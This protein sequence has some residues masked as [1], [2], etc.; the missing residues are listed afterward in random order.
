MILRAETTRFP[1]WVMSFLM[2]MA[3]AAHADTAVATP[4][5][6]IPTP[7]VNGQN[8]LD[9]YMATADDSYAWKLLEQ[10][11]AP[12]GTSYS[13]HMTSQ[14]W[15]RPDEV[16]RTEWEHSLTIVKPANVQAD[17]ALLFIGGG[18][19]GGD[20]RSIDPKLAQVALATG[21]VVAELGMVPNQPLIFHGDGQPRYEDDL[22]AYAWAHFLETGDKRWLPRLP[23]VKSAVRAMD[24]IQALMASE[25]GGPLEVKRFVVAGGSKR[26][27]TTW[28][29]AAADRRVAGIMPIVID[30]LNMD[31]SMRHH[32]SAYGFW[33]PAIGDYVHHG[34]MDQ[35][36]SPRYETLLGL[37]DPFAYRDR[38]TMPK[39]VI[40]ATGDQ[41]FVP[42]SSQFYFDELP[43]EKH[44]CYVPNAE[45]SLDK[46]DAL[47]TLIAFHYSIVHDVPRRNSGG[48]TA[49]PTRFA[50]NA[51][52]RLRA[53][54]H[55]GRPRTTLR[56]IF[57][58]I[59]LGVAI[60][61]WNLRRAIG[62]TNSSPGSTI[63]RKVGKPISSNWSS[64]LA[65]PARCV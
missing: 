14:K 18:R 34:I 27:W 30:M 53:A 5:R 8:V 63:H 54:S 21:S 57:A 25:E 1:Y 51:P 17:T 13:V 28:M 9:R 35:R 62:R 59:R 6:A 43:Q 65:R 23:M 36:Y 58:S 49:M 19:N 22:I 32:F 41:F 3:P 15:L 12:Q 20:E 4:R 2:L 39:C 52:S 48:R 44:L 31:V 29:T 60:E 26:G 50:S 45:H 24:T 11:A 47:D 56:E 64:T 38:Y 37:V 40:N 55:C 42:D 7:Q 10:K 16:D 61:V 33:A 46:T